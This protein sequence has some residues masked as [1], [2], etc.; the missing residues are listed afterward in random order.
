MLLTNFTF[1]LLFW[2]GLKK[3]YFVLIFLFGWAFLWCPV[4]KE[5]TNNF[6]EEPKDFQE[7]S[8]MES[9]Y[10][11]SFLMHYYTSTTYQRRPQILYIH[12]YNIFVLDFLSQLDQAYDMIKSQCSQLIILR[13]LI[14]L[15]TSFLLSAVV[16][17]HYLLT[18]KVYRVEV[19]LLV[20][21]GYLMRPFLVSCHSGFE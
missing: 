14:H 21:K 15:S 3:N 11:L 16:M 6:T 5:V 20:V 1:F 8:F 9:G 4:G 12:Q 2:L 10:L 13:D 17:S 19:L 18:S 7:F